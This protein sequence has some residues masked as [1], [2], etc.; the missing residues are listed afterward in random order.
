[1]K[2]RTTRDVRRVLGI[3]LMYSELVQGIPLIFSHFIGNIP[4]IHSIV[5]FVSI[6]AISV[7]SVPSEERFLLQQVESREYRVF[8]CFVRHGYDDVFKDPAEFEL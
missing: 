8:R 1:M 6:K 5:V 2:W 7:S 4:S 3:K